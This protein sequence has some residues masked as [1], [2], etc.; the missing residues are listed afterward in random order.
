VTVF[1]CSVILLGFIAETEGVHCSV[2]TESLDTFQGNLSL[3]MAVPWFRRLVAGFCPQKPGFDPGS[4]RMI[5]MVDV[6]GT[7]ERFSSA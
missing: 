3:H 7:E 1:V 2:R 6:S 5:F 4:V